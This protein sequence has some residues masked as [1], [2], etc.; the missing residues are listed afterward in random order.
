MNIT[1]I[2]KLDVRV[3]DHHNV[4]ENYKAYIDGTIEQLRH[5][6]EQA[7]IDIQ[8]LEATKRALSFTQRSDYLEPEMPKVKTLEK[9]EGHE[10]PVT[11]DPDLDKQLTE[12]IDQSLAESEQKPA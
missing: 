1:H 4:T 12:G 8:N 3:H 7:E 10:Q 11:E 6:I 5:T 2:G 9:D